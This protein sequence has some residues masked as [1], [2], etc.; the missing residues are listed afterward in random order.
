VLDVPQEARA[1]M[2]GLMLSGTGK[3]WLGAVRFE[4]VDASVP[5]T[6]LIADR[7]PREDT[8]IGRV[9]EVWF[10]RR[11]VEAFSYRSRVQPDGSWKDN[12]AGV[13][14]VSGD[15]VHGT[16]NQ[17]PLRLTVHTGGRSTLIEGTWGPEQVRIELGPEKLTLKHGIF[18]RE[19]TRE[20]ERPEY[21][22][23]CIR[24]RR[25]EGLSRSDQLDVCGE[26][27]GKKPPLAQLVLA[28]LNTGFRPV[29]PPHV[30]VPSPPVPSRQP[31]M[32]AAPR[33]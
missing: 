27:L 21:D 5:V 26:A 25:G 6:N 2:A 4:T 1:I 10:S 15:T 14:S 8:A 24:Y 28:F 31:S 33:Y 20:E 16:F 29:T 22:R 12:R 3:A 32:G 19:L 9:G 18:E 17:H 23:R 30:T 13:L 7:S 11:Q